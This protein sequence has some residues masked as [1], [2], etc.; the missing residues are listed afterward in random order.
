[1]REEIKDL[2]FKRY[3]L[4]GIM[5]LIGYFAIKGMDIDSNTINF[6]LAVVLGRI[7]ENLDNF[8]LSEFKNVTST[9]K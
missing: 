2:N 3:V 9:Q 1:M 8:I 7:I 4:S 5:V 6:L